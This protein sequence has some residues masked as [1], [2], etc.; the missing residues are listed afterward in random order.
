M[1]TRRD[2]GRTTGRTYDQF[3]GVAAALDVVGNRWSLLVIREL[4][5]GPKRYTDLLDGLPGIPTDVLAARLREF[6]EA[7][8]VER[9]VLPPPAASR[10][11]RLTE[12]GRDLEPA[13]VAL[14]RWGLRRLPSQGP[15]AFKPSWLAVALKALFRPETAQGL[16]TTVDVVVAGDRLRVAIDHGTL[17]F[18][19]HPTGEPDAVIEADPRTL[20][21]AAIDAGA[22]ATALAR[23]TLRVTG[24]PDALTAIQESFSLAPAS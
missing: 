11:Y 22:A 4:L 23:G 5:D 13:I 6:E 17:S 20:L 7:G 9:D 3:C 15:A 8:L 16:S 19:H 18:D 24:D 1:A 12:I 2:A 10:V 14:A 21:T